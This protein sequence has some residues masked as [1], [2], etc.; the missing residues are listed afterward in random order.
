[1]LRLA[2]VLLFSRFFSVAEAQTP[3]TNV[4]ESQLNT[5]HGWKDRVEN[6]DPH[7][8]VALHLTI[9]CPPQ[10]GF[11]R[12]EYVSTMDPLVNWGLD[13]PIESGGNLAI[14]IPAPRVGCGGGIDA[15]VFS[16]AHSTGDPEAIRD[17]YRRRLGMSEGIALSLPFLDQISSSEAHAA[18]VANTLAAISKKR[19]RD[20]TRPDAEG[21]GEFYMLGVVVSFLRSQHGWIVPSDRTAARKPG[22][23]ETMTSLGIPR[24]QA[25]AIVLKRKLEEWN[26]DLEGH[27]QPPPGK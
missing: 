3:L 12:S 27:L 20:L 6:H 18:D 24:E 21:S 22:I 19:S 1:M 11:G 2:V 7:A 25:H 8:I 17:I 23:E 26:A 14:D 13:H 10:D 15:V 16:D 4:I 9:T 5:L